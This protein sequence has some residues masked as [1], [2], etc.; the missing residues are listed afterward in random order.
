MK[1]LSLFLLLS[2]PGLLFAEGWKKNIIDN[3]VTG[4]MVVVAGDITEDGKTDVIVGSFRENKVYAY[5]NYLEGFVKDTVDYYLAGPS[6]MCLADID[7]NGYPNILAAGVD[8]SIRWYKRVDSR[9]QAISIDIDFVGAQCICAMDM[10]GDGDQDVL[11]LSL[12]QKRVVWFENKHKINPGRWDMHV[13]GADLKYPLG[14]CAADINN[15]G[16]TDVA[17]IDAGNNTLNLFERTIGAWVLHQIDLGKDRPS[18]LCL[19]D[20]DRDNRPDIILTLPVTDQVVYFRNEYPQWRKNVISEFFAAP[21]RACACDIDLNGSVDILLTSYENSR[22]SWFTFVGDEW[23]ENKIDDELPGAFCPFMADI[24]NDTDPDLVICTM[25]QAGVVWYANPTNASTA[26]RLE[27]VPDEYA[28][29]PNYPNP[30]NPE[31]GIRFSLPSTNHVTV[32]IFDLTGRKVAV[33]VD[34]NHSP[35][36]YT[37]KWDAS[38]QAAGIYFCTMRAGN[39]VKTRK[40]ILLK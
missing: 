9:W 27:M 6:A 40:M 22:V 24:D 28:L 37:V 25:E 20:L 32:A 23:V 10:D 17:V 7:N 29:Y 30:F 21:W 31:T 38:R 35:G 1:M 11:A 4:A 19:A 34:A 39:F 26:N 33:L 13:I 36:N 15:D 3:K 14:I 5:S 16:L 12:V 8:G 18:S 2:L